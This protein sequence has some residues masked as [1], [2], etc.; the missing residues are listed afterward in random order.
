MYIPKVGETLTGNI[1]L[2]A[3]EAASFYRAGYGAVVVTEVLTVSDWFATIFTKAD[4]EAPVANLVGNYF[5]AKV[6]ANLFSD[7]DLADLE[8]CE[9]PNFS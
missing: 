5:G 6:A 7:S 8:W 4:M 2:W 1:S 3:D 9:F